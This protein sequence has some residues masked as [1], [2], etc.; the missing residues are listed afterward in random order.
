MH[1]LGEAERDAGRISLARQL[2]TAALREHRPFRNRRAMAYDLE[3]LAVAEALSG[4]RREALVY[5]CAA[6]R[7][8]DE[9]GSPIPPAEQAAL[10]RTMGP[11]LA[12]LTPAEERDARAEGQTRPLEAIVAS[13]LELVPEEGDKIKAKG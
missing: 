9:A 12:A 4:R 6:Q 11:L 5:L 8:R 1:S 3:G 13:A 10:S 7:L 2:F